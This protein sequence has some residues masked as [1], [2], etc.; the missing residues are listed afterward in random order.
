[1]K[2]ILIALVSM[3]VATFVFAQQDLVDRTKPITITD[4]IVE[5]TAWEGTIM[6]M[7]VKDA[8]GYGVVSNGWEGNYTN[9]VPPVVIPPTPTVQII[10]QAAIFK[11]VMR[12]YFGDGAETNRNITA[13]VVQTYFMNKQL[14]GIIT[15][16]ELADAIVLDKLFASLIEFTGTG[17]SWTFPWEIVP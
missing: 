11:M 6:R 8:I 10:Q 5:Y 17:E 9:E 15:V 1:M 2:R 12:K 16:Q 4:G 7:S 13:T 14:G 3:F